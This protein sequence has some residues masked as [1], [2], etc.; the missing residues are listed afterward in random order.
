MCNGIPYRCLLWCT[1]FFSC[2]FLGGLA[3]SWW[4][5]REEWR[6]DPWDG[7]GKKSGCSK[8]LALH[9]I[10]ACTFQA[11]KRNK[12]GLRQP[13]VANLLWHREFPFQVDRNARLT[14]IFY[15]RILR[16]DFHTDTRG[17]GGK[18]SGSRASGRAQLGEEGPA[19]PRAHRSVERRDRE[20]RTVT[21]RLE[22]D[23]PRAGME[24]ML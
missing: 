24:R 2:S 6:S 23:R 16:C 20:S 17:C 5:C 12:L 11:D 8:T 4:V 10:I 14:F 19:R 1:L 9:R 13:Q 7:G 3:V 18:A 15:S 21:W 22:T